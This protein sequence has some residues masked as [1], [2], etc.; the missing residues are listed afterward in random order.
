MQACLWVGS[1]IG[2]GL[3]GWR[4]QDHSLPVQDHRTCRIPSTRSY[5]LRGPWSMS[6]Q[7]HTYHRAAL[8][9]SRLAQVLP[10]GLSV[11]PAGE[12]HRIIGLGCSQARARGEDCHARTHAGRTQ[13][14]TLNDQSVGKLSVDPRQGEIGL[15]GGQ[16]WG[17]IRSDCKAHCRCRT[18]R[19]S[20]CCAAR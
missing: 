1:T 18:C 7:W 11:T 3:A 2:L 9:R 15:A 4:V 13:R 14:S 10:S 12:S 6:G 20:H 19:R 5:D 16:E 17:S 8:M